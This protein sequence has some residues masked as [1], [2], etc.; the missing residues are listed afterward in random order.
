[1]IVPDDVL[2]IMSGVNPDAVE[3]EAHDLKKAAGGIRETGSNVHS[4]WQGLSAFYE[5]PEA[6]DLFAATAPVRDDSASFAGQLEKVTGALTTYAAETRVIKRKLTDLYMQS[7][8]FV[9]KT[10]AE[11]GDWRENEDLVDQ[12]NSLLSSVNTQALAFQNA[13]EKAANNIYAAYGG[14]APKRLMCT[15]DKPPSW[16]TAEE[17]ENPWY[18]DLWDGVA[19][20]FTGFFGDGFWGDASGIWDLVTSPEKWR[21]SFENLMI[22]GNPIVSLAYPN[23]R[24]K[25]SE[26]WKGF[27]KSFVAW[28]QWKDD[29]ARALGNTA[30]NIVTTIIPIGKAGS[31]G[32]LAKSTRAASKVGEA[33][34]PLSL[35]LRAGA[36]L[37]KVSDIAAKLT[38]K[39]G[40]LPTKLKLDLTRTKI[41]TPHVDPATITWDRPPPT[42]TPEAPTPT[43]PNTST[44]TRTTPNSPAETQTPDHLPEWVLRDHQQSATQTVQ[45]S[46]ERTPDHA[47]SPALV[48]LVI[49]ALPTPPTA[50]RALRRPRRAVPVFPTRAQVFH[51]RAT[52]AVRYAAPVGQCHHTVE[53]VALHKAPVGATPD[54]K[55]DRS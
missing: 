38:H 15:D 17:A 23:L 2:S 50:L 29:P 49:L 12:N 44:P 31:A 27:G 3:A 45:T 28:D 48:A 37:P 36:K 43:T 34:D 35:T 13:Q 24:K 41:I 19:S 54:S 21:E 26:T 25:F 33:L 11:D 42:R 51:N 1:M 10:Y 7:V 52:S 32:K 16:G 46:H 18:E 5:A 30:Y 4:T 22:L 47:R 8:T 40:D 53:E 6:A 9:N 20:F 14:S 39:F 55:T